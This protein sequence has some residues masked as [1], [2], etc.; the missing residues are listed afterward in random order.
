M[1]RVCRSEKNMKACY[2]DQS[3]E[4]KSQRIK[5]IYI[6]QVRIHVYQSQQSYFD[7]CTKSKERILAANIPLSRYCIYLA[8]MWGSQGIIVFLSVEW[9][10]PLSILVTRNPNWSQRSGT[11]TGC[12]KRR[13]E[14]PRYA[15]HKVSCIV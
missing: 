3:F 10:S 5:G 9:K 6:S 7:R 14:H 1:A 15:L 12:I 2:E 11:E 4:R 8:N 13:Y